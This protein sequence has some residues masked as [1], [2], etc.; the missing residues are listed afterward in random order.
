[1][2]TVSR[3]IQGE[4]LKA[5]AFVTVAFLALFAFI[6]FV[7][8]LRWVESGNPQGYQIRHALA[9]VATLSASTLYDLIPITMLI[10]S[11]FVM[12][13]LAQHSEFTVLRTSGLSPGRALRIMLGLGLGFTL[14]TFAIGDFVA[15]AADRAGQLLR[16][17][18]LREVTI[19]QTGAWL[20]EKQAFNSYAVNVG[21]LQSDGSMRKV[22]IIEFDSHGRLSSIS[23]AK[24][25][26]FGTDDSWLLKDVTRTEFN[27]DPATISRAQREKLSDLRWPTS[28][29]GEMVTVA[30]LRPER[31]PTIDLFQFMRHLDANGQSSQRYEIE[32]WR[33]VFYPLSCL[34]MAVLALPFAYLHF[35]TRGISTFVFIGVMTGISFFLLNDLFGYFGN[36]RN[37]WPWLTAAAPGLLY[38]LLSLSAFSWLVLRR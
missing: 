4:V 2:K 16:A 25:G 29:T 32:F 35:R 3:M 1:M 21:V 27:A 5:V 11:V 37:W 6:D 15:P 31:M 19:G 10:G 9:F 34:V 28:L 38:S 8:E 33:K 20:R 30:L 22:R 18:Y 26:Q 14:L 36:L 23:E 17:K 24:T 7:D 12:A 13:R